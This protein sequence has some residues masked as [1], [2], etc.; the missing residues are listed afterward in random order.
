MPLTKAVTNIKLGEVNSSKLRALNEVWSAYK[1]LCDAYLAYFCHEV[2]PDGYA[3]LVFS[4]P[5]SQRW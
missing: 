3:E 2:A 4:S 1:T 5:L